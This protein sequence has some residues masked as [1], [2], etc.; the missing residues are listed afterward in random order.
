MTTTHG[1]RHKT[2][3]S[4]LSEMVSGIRSP[5]PTVLV[6]SVSGQEPFVCNINPSVTCSPI[7]YT[8]FS[9]L[10]PYPSS[11]VTTKIS[12]RVLSGRPERHLVLLKYKLDSRLYS[13]GTPFQIPVSLVVHTS[14]PPLTR[15]TST[16]CPRD[17]PIGPPHVLHP[18]VHPFFPVALLLHKRCR[19]V[20]NIL[21]ETFVRLPVFKPI[22]HYFI[23]YSRCDIDLTLL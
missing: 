5:T 8:R 12:L 20:Y 19:F 11:V 1:K 10:S 18:P 9:F 4:E 16:P 22:S 6:L 21:S 13:L 2:L 23:Y 3:R 14:G 15:I 17:G 7:T